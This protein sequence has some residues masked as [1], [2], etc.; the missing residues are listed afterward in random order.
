MAKVNPTIRQARTSK[1]TKALWDSK[2]LKLEECKAKLAFYELVGISNTETGAKV[3]N[4]FHVA[5]SEAAKIY[6]GAI[7]NPGIRDNYVNSMS[8]LDELITNKETGLLFGLTILA[9]YVRE[10]SGLEFAAPAS[11]SPVPAEAEGEE[12]SE[13]L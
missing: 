10:N 2:G 3:A 5:C 1:E 8:E 12:I 13:E 7:K 9:N 11:S 4:L 6:E